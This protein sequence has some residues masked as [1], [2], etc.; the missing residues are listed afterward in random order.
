M[1][2]IEI[3]E[4][5]HL[6]SPIHQWDPRAKIV[7]ILT[8]IFS[9]VLLYDLELAALG[10]IFAV[11]L[12]LISKIPL[13]FVMWHL[14]WVVLFIL[15]FFLI[16]PFAVLEGDITVNPEGFEYAF[17]ILIKAISAVILIF[18]MIG[19]M[20][21]NST[22]K[23][24]ERLKIPNKIVQMII[25][26]YRYIFVFIDEFSD[27]SRSLDSRGFRRRTNMHTIRTLGKAIGMLFVKSYERSERVYNAMCSR[28]Y[29]GN[30]KTFDK[31][32]MMRNDWVK[33]FIVMGMAIGL[34]LLHFIYFMEMI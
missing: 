10:L 14:R 26:T 3:D 31:F 27:I 34:H 33:M 9:V 23:A 19:T 20:R 15:P 6:M 1:E 24:L 12:L 21:F 22:A 17:L 8:L 18:P 5:H 25:F 16:M 4:Y 11:I 2:Y 29:T 28:G 7:S 30:L 13:K 32:E